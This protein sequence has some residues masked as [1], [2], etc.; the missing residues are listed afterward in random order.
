MWDCECRCKLVGLIQTQLG[1]DGIN[2]YKDYASFGHQWCLGASPNYLD[3]ASWILF[4]C[5]HVLRTWY[6][7]VLANDNV[8]RAVRK[9]RQLHPLH[10]LK[11]Q[12]PS[13]VHLQIMFFIKFATSDNFTFAN[14]GISHQRGIANVLHNER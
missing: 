12:E 3:I 10:N 7:V 9:R 11:G 4:D 8:D 2:V 1:I 14:Y 13:K 6:D 5:Q